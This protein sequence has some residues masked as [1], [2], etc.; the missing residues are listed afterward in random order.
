MSDARFHTPM[1]ARRRRKGSPPWGSFAAR[2]RRS[3]P[4]WGRGSCVSPRACER[5]C[6]L[7]A[8]YQGPALT[9]LPS[10][11]VRPSDRRTERHHTREREL[12]LLNVRVRMGA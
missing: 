7:L 3:A 1:G 2:V 6:T 12:D 10:R 11:P 4:T 8:A 5:L 9:W